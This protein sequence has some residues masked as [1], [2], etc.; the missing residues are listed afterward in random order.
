MEPH[1]TVDPYKP[2]SVVSFLELIKEFSNQV[3]IGGSLSIIPTHAS[4]LGAVVSFIENKSVSSSNLVVPGFENLNVRN[5]LA[6]HYQIPPQFKQ[7]ASFILN[8]LREMLDKP[9]NANI[10]NHLLQSQAASASLDPK[11]TKA[12]TKAKNHLVEA[13]VKCSYQAPPAKGDGKG[14]NN[15][16]SRKFSWIIEALHNCNRDLNQLRNLPRLFSSPDPVE[17]QRDLQTRYDDI[18]ELITSMDFLEH[19]IF[20]PHR[21]LFSFI[22]DKLRTEVHIVM[23]LRNESASDEVNVAFRD[24]MTEDGFDYNFSTWAP[25]AKRCAE[26]ALYFHQRR[27]INKDEMKVNGSAV[28]DRMEYIGK[29]VTF[30]DII[31]TY[32]RWGPD[33]KLPDPPRKGTNDNLAIARTYLR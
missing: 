11:N 13:F 9:S 3:T 19:C 24:K 25:V 18:M 5:F 1:C 15:H 21:E 27:C 29:S 17:Q 10:R 20:L 26:Q 16:F 2:P 32:F 28:R 14:R 30:F 12:W 31:E 33:P 4:S 22:R 6:R 23:L 8:C 7:N